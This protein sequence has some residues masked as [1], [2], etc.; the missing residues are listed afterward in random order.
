MTI[1]NKFNRLNIE[2]LP[3]GIESYNNENVYFCTPRGAK[4]IGWAG[5]DGIHFCFIRGFGEMVFAISPMNTPGNYV[6]PLANSFSDFLRLLLACGN[7]APLE[8]AYSWNQ[9]QFE[10]FLLENPIAEEQLS[11]LNII[12][13]KLYM[14]PMDNPFEYIKQLQA[15]FD[16]SKIKFTEDYEHFLPQEP[17]LPEWNVYFDGN[18]WGYSARQKPGKDISTQT[19][20]N[21]NDKA[22][23]IPFIY[24]CSKGLVIDFCVQIPAERIYSFIDKWGLSPE[25]DGGSFTEEQQMQMETENPMVINIS[26]EIVLN[27]KT[28]SY[29]HGSGLSWNPCFPEQN[30]MESDG[31]CK[32]YGLDQTSGW[33]IWRSAFPWQ[34]KRKPK[35]TSLSVIIKHDPINICSSHFS[36]SAPGEY[37]DFT[38]PTTQTLHTLTVQEYEQQEIPT[39]RF[40]DDYDFPSH[41]TAMSYTISPDLAGE[42]F[43]VHDC[44]SGD[45][46]RK[47]HRNS[48]EPQST[49]DCFSV[50]IIGGAHR[51]TAIPFCD[52]EQGKLRA[53]CSALHF[54]PVN[55]VE[56]KIVFH[57]KPCADMTVKII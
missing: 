38:N 44:S 28:I 34:T 6:H 50:G 36:I 56:W 16:Y 20:F 11:V 24:T 32:H 3:L 26:S 12:S 7:T 22:W 4:I 42:S 53:V 49:A 41:C 18:F 23:Y 31:V 39:D 5:V 54:E 8:Q 52:S 10:S 1:Y 45:R 2:T 35:I 37:I 14:Q 27:G 21:L 48:M 13:E 17:T 43:S 46:P 40:S 9:T 47:K 15:D 51:P 29:S 19:H 25:N 57:K 33:I 30:G 55:T